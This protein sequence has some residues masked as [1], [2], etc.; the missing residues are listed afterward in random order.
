MRNAV[1][2]VSDFV[3]V[4]TGVVMVALLVVLAVRLYEV[5]MES[6]SDLKYLGSRQSVRRVQT[7]G[8]RGRILDRNGTVLA[9]NRRSVSIVLNP[10]N[11][12]RRTWAETAEA[13]S[14]AIVRAGKIVGRGDIPGG[15]VIRR[16]IDQRLAMPLTVWRNVTFEELSRFSEHE[17]EL[18]GFESS[19]TVERVYPQGMFAAHVLGYVGRDETQGDA[20]DE[21]IHFRDKEMK[22]RAGLEFFYNEYLRGVPG[23]KRLVVDARGFTREESVA[24]EPRAGPDLRLSLDA[25]IQRAVERQLAGVRGACVVIDPRDGGVLALASNPQFDPNTFVPMLRQELYDRHVKDPAMPLLNRAT[26]GAYAP[27]SIFK[28]VVALA[29]LRAGFPEDERYECC[30]LFELGRMRLHCARRWGHGELDLRYALMHSCNPFFVNAGV[31]IGTNAVLGAARDFGL[32]RKSGIDLGIERAGIVPDDAWK[33]S[34]YGENWYP[35]DLAQISIGQGML[36]VTPLQMACMA[37]ALAT[38]Y[39]VTPHLRSDAPV[40]RVRVPFSEHDLAVVREGMEMVVNGRGRVNG[41]GRKGG[42]GVAVKVAGKTGTAEVGSRANR[43]KNAWFIA[44]APAENPTVAVAMIVER[45]DSGGETAAPR[46]CA[47]LKHVFGTK[48]DD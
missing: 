31:D 2:I 37:G 46:V 25:G 44:Y 1:S 39:L 45:G 41:T 28:P 15:N 8:D 35:G 11:F 17:D 16:H 18:S 5:Q 32:G 19:V 42:Q 48:K 43:R 24:V 27:G 36:L 14:N 20:G 13:I 40:E 6:S 26:A 22:G 10:E 29:A 21:R 33:R 12:Q 3:I 34:V 38:G 9:D 7:A 30:G 4:A 23:E 47:V